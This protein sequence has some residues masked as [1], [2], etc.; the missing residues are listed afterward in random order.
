MHYTRLLA[1][2]AAPV[3]SSRSESIAQAVRLLALFFGTGSETSW[4]AIASLAVAVTFASDYL[5][6]MFCKHSPN[7]YAAVLPGITMKTLAYVDRT[8]MTEFHLAQGAC[9]PPHS[10]SHEQ[11]GYLVSGRLRLTIGQAQFEVGAGD[12]WCIEGNVEHSAEA[13]HDTVALEVFSPV[14]ADYLPP[15][16][17]RRKS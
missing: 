10:H 2:R 5:L 4:L 13:L 17:E 11:T 15:V 9:L 12:S 7:G 14:R 3:S 16:H 8:L 6:D 1:K